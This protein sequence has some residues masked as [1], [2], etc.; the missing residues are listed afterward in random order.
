MTVREWK[1]AIKKLSAMGISS[2]AFTGGE[3]LLRKGIFEIMAFAA[4]CTA[5]HIETVGDSLMGEDR[6]PELY[7]L[8]NEGLL[9]CRQV[10]YSG[11]PGC[12]IS[13]FCH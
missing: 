5:I 10:S 7:L 9:S 6:P 1:D 4:E 8:S 13:I 12:L 3:P 2:F 11:L